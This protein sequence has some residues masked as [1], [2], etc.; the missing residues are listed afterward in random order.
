MLAFSLVLKAKSSIYGTRTS[1]R[2]NTTASLVR[3]LNI[4]GSSIG[5][6]DSD[7]CKMVKNY[8][9]TGGTHYTTLGPWSN[10]GVGVLSALHAACLGHHC[11]RCKEIKLLS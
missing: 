6:S 10:Y 2:P 11:A 5:R 7:H 8:H 9:W 4:R 3:R 1:K